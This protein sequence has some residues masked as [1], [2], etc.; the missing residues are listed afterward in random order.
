MEDNKNNLGVSQP[1]EEFNIQEVL[2]RYLIHWPWFVAS[3]LICVACA[4]GYLKIA[5]PIYNVSATVLIKEDKKSGGASMTSELEKVGLGGMMTSTNG[6]DNE[7]EVLKSKSI[8]L[9]VV[10]QLNL[11][12]T[13][14]DE[15]EFPKKSYIVLLRS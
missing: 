14:R 4:F 7:I 11:Y 13:Y 15:D 2:F 9:E 10:E 8:A 6:V 12:V 5:T 1:E 3:V